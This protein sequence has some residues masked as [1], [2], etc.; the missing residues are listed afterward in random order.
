M[1]KQTTQSNNACWLKTWQQHPLHIHHS[2]MPVPAST[3]TAQQPQGPPTPHL[4]P[5]NGAPALPPAPA[6]LLLGSP[7]AAATAAPAPA[8]AGLPAAPPAL[9]PC[10]LGSCQCTSCH[11]ATSTC[12]PCYCCCRAKLAPGPSCALFPA[13]G[14][15]AARA[16]RC[17]CSAA[18]CCC[19]PLLEL[20]LVVYVHHAVVPAGGWDKIST[21]SNVQ[22]SLH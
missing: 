6:L 22:C 5:C 9:A 21:H 11:K 14:C 16:C 7:T 18:P 3:P 17:A 1:A 10:R 13:A 4:L 20:A 12:C 19:R 2:K 8:T 15:S